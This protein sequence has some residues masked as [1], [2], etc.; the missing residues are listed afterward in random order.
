MNQKTVTIIDEFQPGNESSE[1]DHNLSGENTNNGMANGRHWRDASDG[2]YFEFDLKVLPGKPC[3]LVLTYWGG[4]SG[5][6]LFDIM[7]DGQQI[8]TQRLSNNFPGE[9][10]DFSYVIDNPKKEKTIRVR[11]QAYPKAV[12]GGIYGAK[13]IHEEGQ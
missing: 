13:T 4:D 11:L 8:G 10:F 12:A 3:N 2:G 7:I 9:F 1:K 5:N 6:R